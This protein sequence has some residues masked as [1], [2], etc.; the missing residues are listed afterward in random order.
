MALAF[1]GVFE[2]ERSIPRPTV[3][4]PLVG[5]VFLIGDTDDPFTPFFPGAEV[6]LVIGVALPVAYAFVII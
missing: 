5:V 3:F 6:Y 2:L 4:V 1:D